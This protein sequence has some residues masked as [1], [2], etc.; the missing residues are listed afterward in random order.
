MAQRVKLIASIHK[1]ERQLYTIAVKTRGQMDWL[2]RRAN[3]AQ[4]E[5]VLWPKGAQQCHSVQL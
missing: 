1:I 4:R 2:L 3:A 5:L